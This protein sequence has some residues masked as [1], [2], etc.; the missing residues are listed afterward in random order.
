MQA[1]LQREARRQQGQ[2]SRVLLAYEDRVSAL[3]DEI[4]T[5]SEDDVLD[6][7][8][9]CQKVCRYVDLP[10]QHASDSVLRRMRRPGTTIPAAVA[11]VP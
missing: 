1:Y 11:V 3:V 2:V 6:A 4:V 5:V 10:L 8:A 9:E 7:M